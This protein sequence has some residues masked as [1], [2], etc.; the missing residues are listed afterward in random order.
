MK[1]YIDCEFDGHNGVLLSMALV[2]EDGCSIHIRTLEAATDPWVALNVVPKMWEHNAETLALVEVNSV[3]SELRRFLHG[4]ANPILIA[5]SPQDIWRFCQ[6]IATADDGGYAPNEIGRMTFEIHDVE[7]YPTTLAGAVQHNAWWDAM[8]LRHKLA[9][10]ISTG[11]A[12]TAKLAQGEA[13]ERGPK[14][15]PTP[16]PHPEGSSH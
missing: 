1:Y 10:A 14:D 5:D 11:T 2:P 15:A 9:Q 3:G 7:P 8:A 16:H 6:S 4:D 13:C 12:E